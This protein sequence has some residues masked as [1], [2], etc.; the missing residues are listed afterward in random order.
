MF[1]SKST[2]K[3][4]FSLDATQSRDLKDW[5]SEELTLLGPP[6]LGGDDG[7]RRTRGFAAEAVARYGSQKGFLKHPHRPL[8]I[9]VF[10]TKGGVLKTSLT[11]NLA[12]M[13]ALHGLRTCVVGLDMQCDITTALGG[14]VRAD[15]TTD[16]SEHLADQDSTQGLYDLFERSVALDDLILATD[17]PHLALI[18]ETP[19][20][21]VLEKALFQKTRRE[22][23]IKEAI[24]EPLT[25]TFDVVIFDCSPN[26]NLLT[27][28]ALVACNWL[29]SPLEC[30]INNYRNFKMFERFVQDFRQELRLDFQQ[31][32]VPTRLNSQRKLSRE[33]YA[34]YLQNVP[35][36]LPLALRESVVGE[37]AIAS[38]LST[39]EYAAGSPSAVE[40][41]Q[42]LKQI[43]ER[44][45]LKQQIHSNVVRDHGALAQ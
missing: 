1:Y 21:V 2:L 32:F 18:P 3:D 9:A 33:I 42:I 24:V 23:W 19:E 26:W 44:M 4:L 36:V 35:H 45:T 34:W 17:L 13:T 11:L 16:F 5:S 22:Q 28:N 15:E 43:W 40:M 37:E 20:L 31:I 38:N 8:V 14:S 30:K 12:R 27:T 6:S 41:N 7:R 10:V 25:K 29:I 39:T